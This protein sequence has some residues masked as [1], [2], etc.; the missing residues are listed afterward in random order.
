MSTSIKNYTKYM[1]MIITLSLM[2]FL[3]YIPP[4]EGVTELGM[5]VLGIFI[6]LIYAWIF[7]G[8]IWPSLL[9]L[10]MLGLSD[11]GTVL[12]MFVE[13][14]GNS[15]VLFIFFLYI[16]VG[17]IDAS[18]LMPVIGQFFVSLKVAQGKPYILMALILF[19][20]W[21][22]GALVSAVAASILMWQ[23]FYGMC[24]FLGYKKGDKY[25]TLVVFGIFYAGLTGATVFPF[26][27]YSIIPVSIYGMFTGNTINVLQ[28]SALAICVTLIG[29]LCYILM[30]KYVFRPEV[31]QKILV[32][33]KPGKLTS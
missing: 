10:L 13:G 1:H 5:E 3:R 16:F 24:D 22:I 21:V 23:V 4:F 19:S 17:A 28:F 15:T 31:S 32:V 25:A 8:L 12:G 26:K 30:C 29:V 6:G 7:C 18:G 27:T 2:L 11:Y 9:G 14:A 33:E 20:A